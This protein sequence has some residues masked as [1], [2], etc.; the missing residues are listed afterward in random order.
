MTA[1][2]IAPPMTVEEFLLL[3]EGADDGR[4][5]LIDGEIFAEPMGGFV[6]D[7]VK[8]NLKDLFEVAGVQSHGYRCLVEQSYEVSPDDLLIPDVSVMR[9]DRLTRPSGGNSPAAGTPEVVFEVSI[10]DQNWVQQKKIS[11]YLDNGAQ[12]VCYVFPE[13]RTVVVYTTDRWRRLREQDTLEFP[14]LLPGLTIP[15]SAIFDNI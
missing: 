7:I 5:E 1:S 11:A 9:R 4:F 15:V 8:N 14:A 2:T 12:A 13:L 3:P 10:T 6:H